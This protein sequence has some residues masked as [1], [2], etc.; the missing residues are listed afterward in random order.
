VDL[1]ARLG[2]QART[3]RELALGVAGH[4]LQPIEINFPLEEFIA[5]ETHIEQIDS[6]LFVAAR[7]IDSL[8]ARASGHALSLA[9]LMVRMTLEGGRRYEREIRPAVPSTDRKFL[10]KLLHLEIAAHPPASAVVTLT[11][12]AE[13]GHSS[14][15]QLGL[16]APQTPEPSRLDV[17]LARLKAL[18]GDDRVG[19]PVLE[20]THASGS[21]RMQDFSIHAQQ[22]P[23]SPERPRMALRRMRPPTPVRVTVHAT[24]PIA[25]RDG[26]KRYEIT[27]AYGPW[28]TSGCWWSPDAWD[29]E[30]WDVLAATG[31]GETETICCLLVLDRPSNRWQLEA[32]Y[33]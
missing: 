11:L 26:A 20:D 12:S 25:F 4:T 23:P 16:F 15:V 10:L 19:S 6:L 33:D 17:T 18:V 28:R 8:A 1:I 27:A 32:M 5:F 22:V 21:F 31:N 29:S 7:M 14:T 30:E 9:S 24:R 3:W 13:A 2:Q